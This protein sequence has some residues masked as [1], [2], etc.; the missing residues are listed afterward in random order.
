MI[1]PQIITG[2]I[3][4]LLPSIC[5]A[6]DTYFLGGL[7]DKTSPNHNQELLD[8]GIMKFP[9]LG[10]LWENIDLKSPPSFKASYWQLLAYTLDKLTMRYFQIGACGLHS[11]C[12]PTAQSIQDKY[13][14]SR[15]Q[16]G[17]EKMTFSTTL[18]GFYFSIFLEIAL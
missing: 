18:V 16:R 1:M 3:L 12:A 8:A 13:I 15:P 14:N 7:F 2:I 9:V 6:N 4:K 11:D 10:R 17:G 5:T